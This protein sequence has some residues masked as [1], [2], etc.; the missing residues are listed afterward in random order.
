MVEKILKYKIKKAKL[1]NAFNKYFL[2]ACMCQET[3]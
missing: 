2:S 1:I 3:F